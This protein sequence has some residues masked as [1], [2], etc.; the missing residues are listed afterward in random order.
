MLDIYR[1]FVTDTSVSFELEPPTAAEFEARIASAQSQWAWLV[2]EKDAQLAG[3]AYGSAF[4]TRAAYRWTVE[5]SAYVHP[6]Q[7][8][9]GIAGALYRRL[10]EVLAEK[11]YCNAYAGIALPNDSSIAF[12]KLLGFTSVGVFH[13]AGWK[14]GQWHDVSWWE[15]TLRDWPIKP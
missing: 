15:V 10:F 3:Y 12:H 1:P 11:G 2:A 13:R 6:A 8:G 4:R 7:R 5:V 14:F 9:Q